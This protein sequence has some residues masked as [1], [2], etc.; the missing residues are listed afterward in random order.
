MTNL[1]KI[2]TMLLIVM[3]LALLAC[4]SKNPLNPVMDT[5]ADQTNKKFTDK[6]LKITIHGKHIYADFIDSKTTREFIA[7][8]PLTLTME[9]LGGREK[10]SS[11]PKE[12]SKEGK[13]STSYEVGDIS[14]WLGGGVAAFYNNDGHQVKAGLIVLA[15]LEKGIV[16]FERQESLKVTFAAVSK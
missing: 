16:L 11:L 14:Y 13:V 4:N 15:R 8:L 6:Q 1:K 5:I 2:T 12:L 10:F 9:D 7:L 3:P